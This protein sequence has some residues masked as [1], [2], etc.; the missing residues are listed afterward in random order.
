MHGTMKNTS[1]KTVVAIAGVA[2][3]LTGS[4]CAKSQGPDVTYKSNEISDPIEPV[5]RF[6]FGFND[7][8]DH[9]LFEPL[10]KGYKAILPSFV[11]DSVQSFMRNLKSPLII[12]NNLLQGDLGNAG[13]ATARFVI[14]STV[15]IAGLIDVAKTQ[16]M[17][18][19]PEDFGQTLASWG[20]GNGFYL[21]LPIL[22]P[23][24]LR[25]A[26]GT[27]V[28]GYADP[29]RIVADNTDN[30]WIYYTREAVEGLDTRSRM[31]AAIDDMRRNNL[32]YY[33]AARSAYT[34]KRL[35]MIRDEK[36]GAS[37]TYESP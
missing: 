20:V 6:V 30:M 1:F 29:V 2:L 23:S 4:A 12:A 17:P 18:Y 31:I 14:N 10:A 33:A 28:D 19:E 15:G 32:D 22:G 21:V 26:T 5:N 11:R 24:S 3:M 16:G 34:Q 8:L 9:V 7:V 37:R 27:L 36:T 25:D 13:V 35:S